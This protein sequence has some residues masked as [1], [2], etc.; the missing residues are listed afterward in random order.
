[1][2]TAFDGDVDI[3]RALEA[4]VQGYALKSSTG[5]KLLPAIRAVA[6]G[7]SWIP[8]EVA[9]RLAARSSFG[10]LTAR[11]DEVL[12]E[13]AKGLSN[14]QI[15]ETLHIT[16]HTVKEHLKHILRK[17]KVAD[18]TEAVMVA[19]QRGIIRL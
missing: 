17:L 19:L 16:E 14:K 4:G 13:L 11:E 3:R 6:G 5:D 7:K 10:Q 18:R 9:A 8:N 1:M 12:Q 15:A 2:L